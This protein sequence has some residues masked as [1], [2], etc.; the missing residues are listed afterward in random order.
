MLTFTEKIKLEKQDGIF[1]IEGEQDGRGFYAL[2]Q[3]N[4]AE[5]EK[6]IR[7]Y[8]QS[9]AF[10]LEKEFIIVESGWL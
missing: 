7:Y 6:L 10:R 3:G 9:Q 1:R 4:K 8:E 2:I 5:Y